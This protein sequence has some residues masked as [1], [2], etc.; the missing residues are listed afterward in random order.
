MGIRYNPNQI[1][2]HKRGFHKD[3]WTLPANKRLVK[4]KALDC[5]FITHSR[6]ARLALLSLF[7]KWGKHDS[8]V[9]Q[10]SKV[11]TGK[12]HFCLPSEPVVV[13][14]RPSLGPFRGG[15]S[16]RAR[17]KA[18]SVTLPPE[19]KRYEEGRCTSPPK[20]LFCYVLDLFPFIWL[21]VT[22]PKT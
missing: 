11:T 19:R 22:W 17:W 14:G 12:W 7:H 3:L 20:H 4:W 18:G 15:W 21:L 5:S 8:E 1:C 2:L 6:P 16:E 9:E 10:P 13:N